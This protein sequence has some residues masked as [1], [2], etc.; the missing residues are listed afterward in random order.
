LKLSARL[1]PRRGWLLATILLG[2]GLLGLT[3][4]PVA[5]ADTVDSADGRRIYRQGILPSGEPLTAIVVGDVPILGTQFSCHN[6][7]GLSGLGAIEGKYI[8][9][10]IAGRFLYA[11]S[12]QPNRPAYDNDSL[13]RA[14]RDGIDPTGRVLDPLMPRFVLSDDEIADLAAYLKGLSSGPSPGVDDEVIRL[15]TVVTDDVDPDEREAVLAVLQTFV[16][17]KNR[18]TRLESE[19]WNRGKT[20]DSKLHTLYR[21]WVLDVWTLSGAREDW[22]EQLES[23]YRRAPVFAMMG[24]LSAGSWS[25][26]GR[27]C[28]RHEI[29]CLFPATDMPDAGKADLYTLYFSR[30]L[31]L[32]ADLIADHLATNPPAGV[33]QVYCAEAPARAAEKLRAALLQEGITVNDL[34]FDCGKSLPVAELTA[35]MAAM[36]DA[37]VILWLRREQLASLEQPLPAAR[38]YLSST[39]LERDLDGPWPA[40]S[41][42][43]FVAHPF[44]LPGASD[45]AM[46]RFLLWAR[47]R[48]VE[49]RYPRLQAEAF[50]ACFATKDALTHVRRYLVR[51]YVLDSL[52]HAQGLASYVPIYPRATLGPRQ[53]FLT[54]GGYLLPVVDGRADTTNAAWIQP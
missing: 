47:T 1:S 6:C 35:R 10:P 13:A 37:A 26:V 29:P 38:I 11:A 52:D 22:D 42:A 48:G 14:L 18:Q 28:E 4:A 32:E 43:V 8:V 36:P 15:A 31:D 53:R 45:S 24:G 44:Y 2:C 34:G 54:K 30:G 21:E 51:D 33:I 50:F 19:R 25:P 5:V 17:E 9:P 49:I 27:F 39:L 3:S 41:E 46:R 40:S 12:A 23:H 16:E 20:P 7:H